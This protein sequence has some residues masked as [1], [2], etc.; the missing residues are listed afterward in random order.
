MGEEQDIPAQKLIDAGMVS[1]EWAI[2]SNC[3]LS[4]DFMAKIEDILTDKDRHIH[5]D[6]RL[7][8]SC[9]PHKEFPLSLL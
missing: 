9:E 5:P 4:L 7:W 1:G 8:I 6:F 3:H 2:L